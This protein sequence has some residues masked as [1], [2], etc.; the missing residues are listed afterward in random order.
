MLSKKDAYNEYLE[1]VVKEY[2]GSPVYRAL[3]FEEWMMIAY[4]EESEQNKWIQKTSD[5]LF[6]KEDNRPPIH[7]TALKMA[8]LLAADR[9]EDIHTKVGAAGIRSDKTLVFGYNGL[10][11][12]VSTDWTN[13]EEKNKRVI[14]AEMNLLRYIKPGE[15]EVLV[16]THSPCVN[17]LPVLAS[18]GIKTIY[19]EQ[20]YHRNLDVDIIAKEFGIEL[21]QVTI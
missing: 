4:P 7:I 19:F 18:Y 9:S 15:I 1:K 5:S 21:K 10:P 20:Y 2:Q 14:H 16:C 13:R 17:C 12:G 6:R 11:P 8:K 3:S